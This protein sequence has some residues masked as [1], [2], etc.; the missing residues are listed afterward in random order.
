MSNND[1]C[2]ICQEEEEECELICPAY[3]CDV[4]C[5]EECREN[6]DIWITENNACPH[7]REVSLNIDVIIETDNAELPEVIIEENNTD[8]NK[9]KKWGN[10]IFILLYPTIILLF[11][12]Y[13]KTIDGFLYFFLIVTYSLLL[14]TILISFATC[15]GNINDTQL[16][17]DYYCFSVLICIVLL[18]CMIINTDLTILIGLIIILIWLHVSIN[19]L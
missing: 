15:C 3:E 19:F 18:I 9:F 2:I 7:C 1:T 4:M 14:A 5:C 13:P 8:L 10:S 17:N 6:L 11:I 16:N 12:Y